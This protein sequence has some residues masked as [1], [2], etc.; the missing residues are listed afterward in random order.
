MQPSRLALVLLSTLASVSG[1][2]TA[3]PLDTTGASQCRTR[4][5]L[6]DADPKGANVRSAPRADAPVIG[7]LALRKRMEPENVEFE[8]V[9]SRD[10]WL[11]IQKGDPAE[12]FT[13]DPAHARDG[14]GW[15][16]GKLV[17][18]VLGRM[19]L[20]AEPRR[21]SAVVAELLGPNWG[22]DSAIVSVIHACRDKYVDV[23]VKTPSGKSLRGWSWAP[24]SNQLTTCDGATAG[25]P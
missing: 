22:P 2:A 9:G 24:C 11:L 4:G 1:A 12:D 21:E 13:L 10:G 5:F 23:T 19:Q 3:A 15:V 17:G 20:R 14:R 8:I 16:S 6:N 18:V 25:E 7:H